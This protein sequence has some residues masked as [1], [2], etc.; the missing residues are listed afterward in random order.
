[1][2]AV[3]DAYI[4]NLNTLYSLLLSRQWLRKMKAVSYYKYN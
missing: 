1:M 3:V 2:D 4:I